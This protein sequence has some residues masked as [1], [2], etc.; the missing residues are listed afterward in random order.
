MTG[1]TGMTGMMQRQ[2]HQSRSFS[3]GIGGLIAG[4]AFFALPTTAFR[5]CTIAGCI[6]SSNCLSGI[7]SQDFQGR[8]GFWSVFFSISGFLRGAHWHRRWRQP[9]GPGTARPRTGSITTH[10]T[11]L[12]RKA[13]SRLL[14]N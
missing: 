2:S 14:K 9:A 12:S 5:T 7:L 8:P 1:M 13:F 3:R 4:I 10:S 11:A 6:P